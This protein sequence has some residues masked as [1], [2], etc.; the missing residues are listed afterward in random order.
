M[1]VPPILIGITIGLA[2]L[3]WLLNNKGADAMYVLFVPILLTLGIAALLRI[4]LWWTIGR[5]LP[6]SE[7]MQ[8]T[9]FREVS[10]KFDHAH[11]GSGLPHLRKLMQWFVEVGSGYLSISPLI[12]LLLL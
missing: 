9:T 2:V 10:E 4:L 7:A 1:R 3:V 11:E 5:S 8:K 12:A 6:S